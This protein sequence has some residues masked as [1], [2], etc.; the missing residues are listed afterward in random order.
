MWPTGPF[1]ENVP[2][3]VLYAARIAANLDDA[4]EAQG[5]TRTAAAE[6]IGVARPT[7]YDVIG[8]NTFPDLHT[9]ARAENALDAS[10]WPDRVRDV[11][12][13]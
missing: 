5:M 6:A 8:G 12:T 11:L 10:L 7:L 3:A 9:L 2:I 13:A 4:I 1:I